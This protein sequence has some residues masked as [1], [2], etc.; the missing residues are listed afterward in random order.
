MRT[1]VSQPPTSDLVVLTPR[2]IARISPHIDHPALHHCSR[3]VHHLRSDGTAPRHVVVGRH[4]HPV[5]R[6]LHRLPGCQHGRDHLRGGQ[7]ARRGWGNAPRCCCRPGVH[8]L[9]V[10][11]RDGP[12]GCEERVRRLDACHGH[13]LRRVCL[14]RRSVLLFRQEDQDVVAETALAVGLARPV[15]HVVPVSGIWQS[16]IKR[17]RVSSESRPCP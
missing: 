1:L 15:L 7:L 12:V 5:R 6:G 17:L 2:N 13:H 3:L 8:Q 4:R 16:V 11:L 14:A 10:E 9:R